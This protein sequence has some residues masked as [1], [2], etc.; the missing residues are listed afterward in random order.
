VDQLAH[1]PFGL[2]GS[3]TARGSGADKKESAATISIGLAI[4]ASELTHRYVSVVVRSVADLS[5][6][7]ACP[8]VWVRGKAL[9]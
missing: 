6:S 1:G 7:I 9:G 2:R 5:V 8:L 3:G 4:S